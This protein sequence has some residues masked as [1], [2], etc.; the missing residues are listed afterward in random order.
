MASAYRR[1]PDFHLLTA[2]YNAAKDKHIADPARTMALNNVIMV[3]MFFSSLFVLTF[4]FIL[5]H[6]YYN[7]KLKATQ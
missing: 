7:V 2:K 3:S 6:L 4:A 5:I 1:A